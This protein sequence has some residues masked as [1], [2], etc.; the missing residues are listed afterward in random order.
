MSI[1]DWFKADPPSKHNRIELTSFPKP[2]RKPA[3]KTLEVM[4]DDVEKYHNAG[5]KEIARNLVAEMGKYATNL[6][7]QQNL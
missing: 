7:R 5:E 6:A 3:Y 1:L 4:L 2:P